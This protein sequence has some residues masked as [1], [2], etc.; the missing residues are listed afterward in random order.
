[1]CSIAV[2]VEGG[3]AFRRNVVL[4][5]SVIRHQKHCMEGERDRRPEHLIPSHPSHPIVARVDLPTF[6]LGLGGAGVGGGGG[7]RGGADQIDRH[8]DERAIENSMR[9]M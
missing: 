6:A 4:L 1:M 9:K 2:V 7:P 5:D 8:F 3:R